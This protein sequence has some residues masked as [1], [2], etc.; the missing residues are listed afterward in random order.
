MVSVVSFLF[1]SGSPIHNYFQSGVAYK[2]VP[3]KKA[4]TQ[5]SKKNICGGVYFMKM[6]DYR[7]QTT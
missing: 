2:R 1:I 7:Q 4:C 6:L 3:Y 5:E